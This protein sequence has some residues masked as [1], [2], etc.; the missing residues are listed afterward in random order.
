MKKILFLL[1]LLPLLGRGLGGGLLSAQTVSNLSVSPGTPS[2]V[3]FDV[4]WNKADLDLKTLWLDSMWVFVDY[5]KNGKMT[6]MLI[7]GGTLTAHSG[8][9]EFIPENTMGA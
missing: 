4:E 1:L 8:T 5:N 2:T 3:T 6:R 9:G 7:S